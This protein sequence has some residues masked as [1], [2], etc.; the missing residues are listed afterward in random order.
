MRG[1]SLGSATAHCNEVDPQ[2][3]DIEENGSF[4]LSMEYEERWNGKNYPALF[5]MHGNLLRIHHAGMS[6]D[7]AWEIWQSAEDAIFPRMGWTPG[8]GKNGKR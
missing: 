6:A 2:R 7:L 3:V 8:R 1:F 5:S 4:L